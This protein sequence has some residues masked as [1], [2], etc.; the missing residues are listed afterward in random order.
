[1]YDSCCFREGNRV[2]SKSSDHDV[3]PD[4]QKHLVR[5]GLRSVS[6][7]IIAG[8][9]VSFERRLDD[10]R[11]VISILMRVWKSIMAGFATTS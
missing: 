8:R 2:V 1:M 9:P 11:R 7:M 3:D 6:S 10:S 4:D 5:M